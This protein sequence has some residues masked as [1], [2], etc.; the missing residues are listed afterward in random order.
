M[1]PVYRR[2][3]YTAAA[4]TSA[5]RCFRLIRGEIKQW[6]YGV[7][8]GMAVRG[9]RRLT[10]ALNDIWREFEG[11]GKC[12][13]SADDYRE[14][15]RWSVVSLRGYTGRARTRAGVP[16]HHVYRRGCHD[17]RRYGWSFYGFPKGDRARGQE[18]ARALAAFCRA[19]VR[20][21]LGDDVALVVAPC[22]S[23]IVS[24]AGDHP[25]DHVVR[26]GARFNRVP[27]GL[28]HL[29]QPRALIR[30][31]RVRLVGSWSMTRNGADVVW[32]DRTPRRRARM[33]RGFP[34]LSRPAR[35]L[36][37]WGTA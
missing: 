21:G 29:A 22:T 10:G 18:Q 36:R 16:R 31:G 30:G 34:S 1:D 8:L 26:F 23:Q 32:Y 4:L 5:R 11:L 28:H 27:P 9:R 35:F 14:G 33:R 25:R 20:A 6:G 37:G 2:R 17:R 24:L 12:S 3:V 19:V 13:D 15:H 7:R